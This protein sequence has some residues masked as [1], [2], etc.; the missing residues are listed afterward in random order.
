M[1][2]SQDNRY[3]TEWNKWMPTFPKS[4]CYV[5]THKLSISFE[6]FVEFFESFFC[7]KFIMKITLTS[8]SL[9]LNFYKKFWNNLFWFWWLKLF[10]FRYGTY[11]VVQNISLIKLILKSFV[12]KVKYT[13]SYFFPLNWLILLVVS[14]M[15]YR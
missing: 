12:L 10:S 5:L 1:D 2:T 7:N 8:S 9:D 13:A 15:P 6:L 11:C 14:L 4:V 3:K